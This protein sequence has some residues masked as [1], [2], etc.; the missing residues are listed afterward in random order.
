MPRL[1]SLPCHTDPR[2]SLATIDG[3]LPFPIRR[4]FFVFGAPSD[5]V[6]AGHRHRRTRQAL[7]C[8]VGRC[9]AVVGEG[10][11]ARSYSLQDPLTCLVVEPEDWLVLRRFGEGTVLLCLASEPYDPDDCIRTPGE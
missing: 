10:S 3:I 4:V 11:G 8:A 1:L 2:G 5:A 9:E 7:V 6:R